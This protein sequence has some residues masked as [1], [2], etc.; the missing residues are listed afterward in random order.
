MRR[1]VYQTLSPP[2]HFRD[3]SMDRAFA[4]GTN[5]YSGITIELDGQD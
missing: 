4:E 3:F 5:Y 1:Q 2:W